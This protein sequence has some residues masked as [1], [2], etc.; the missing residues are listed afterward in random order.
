MFRGNAARAQPNTTSNWKWPMD[1]LGKHGV[2]FLL[3]FAAY[4][5][6]SCFY[7]CFPRPARKQ[8]EHTAFPKT[9]HGKETERISV[10]IF[11]VCSFFAQK[12]HTV[13]Q[14]SP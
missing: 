8:R 2:M 5:L 9:K 1:L 4:L 13:F 3:Q 7:N 14:L 12:K 6:Y 11:V 10:Y